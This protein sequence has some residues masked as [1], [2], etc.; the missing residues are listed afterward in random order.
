M[1]KKDLKSNLDNIDTFIEYQGYWSEKVT[2]SK[3]YHEI[4][5]EKLP[6]QSQLIKNGTMI[7]PNV[8][9]INDVVKVI[10]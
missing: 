3:I 9:N 10:E 5:T 7:W 4:C 8:Y 1:A 2:F 6:V